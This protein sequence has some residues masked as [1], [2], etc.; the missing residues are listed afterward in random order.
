MSF[1]VVIP[2]YNEAKRLP[3][4]LRQ[5]NNWLQKEP[6]DVELLFVDDG[7]TDQTAQILMQAELGRVL[8]LPE[9]LG[10]GGAI[11][12]GILAIPSADYILMADVD[13]SAPLE[14]WRALHAVAEKENADLV[15]GSRRLATPAHQPKRPLL[16]RLASSTFALLAKLV[17]VRG[18]ADTQC[19][20]KLL[21]TATLRP[22]VKALRC[23]GFAF[24]VE[25]ILS[26]QRQGLRIIEHPIQWHDVGH[27]SV[28]LF[29]HAPKMIG[30]LFL[31]F[32]RSKR[33]V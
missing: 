19:G 10:K 11:R 17:G 23:R 1:A 13:C 28:N 26:A 5:I 12:A 14:Q 4:A 22:L 33:H 16:R 3:T 25:L 20:F 21:R 27:S 18:I 32:I 9:H 2:C 15:I 7:S 29:R 31:I 24:D 6:T 30:E 8:I